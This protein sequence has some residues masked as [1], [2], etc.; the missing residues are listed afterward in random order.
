L[1]NYAQVVEL[2]LPASGGT[3]QKTVSAPGTREALAATAVAVEAG[4][5]V[6]PIATNAGTV[7][8]FLNETDT[9]GWPMPGDG[10]SL[11]VEIN[12]LSKVFVDAANAGDGVV[13]IYS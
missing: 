6:K 5:L 7:Y 9:V 12:D 3:G 13:F 8:L 11:F 1:S 10:S 2:Q 4:V